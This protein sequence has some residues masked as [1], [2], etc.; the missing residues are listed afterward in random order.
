MRNPSIEPS[1]L[2]HAEPLYAR[3]R[4]EVATMDAQIMGEST[5]EQYLKRVFDDVTLT[6]MAETLLAVAGHCETL[7]A[8]A[9][10]E[11][12]CT[13]AYQ[14]IQGWCLHQIGSATEPTQAERAS[15]TRRSEAP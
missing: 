4:R 15:T 8:L 5:K 11:P 2:S 12:S 7:A 3:V 9:A 13:E 1:Q 14:A 6:V 10:A